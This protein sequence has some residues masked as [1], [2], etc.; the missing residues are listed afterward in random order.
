MQNAEAAS[1]SRWTG[2][3]RLRRTVDYVADIAGAAAGFRVGLLHLELPPRMLEWEA[4]RGRECG[5]TRV[6]RTREGLRP[7]GK[8]DDRER[9]SR[10]AAVA[11][12]AHG[13]ARGSRRPHGAYLKSRS[14]RTAI[15]AAILKTAAGTSKRGTVIVGRHSFTG[16]VG[17]FRSIMSRKTS[18]A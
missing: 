5:T 1:R 12:T 17:T 16:L 10:I 11:A 14:I 6:L 15:A 3:L 18:C 9:R 8:G 4:L 7:A 13:P 2:R